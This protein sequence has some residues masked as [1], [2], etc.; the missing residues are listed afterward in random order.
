MK[1]KGL[2]FLV[3]ALLVN[4]CNASWFSSVVHAIT[5]PKSTV[6]TVV[7]DTKGAVDS[8]ADKTDALIKKSDDAIAKGME[9]ADKGIVTAGMKTYGGL[10][11]A[12]K[13]A[14]NGIIHAVDNVSWRQVAGFTLYLIIDYGFTAA[15]TA[16]CGPPCGILGD[17]AGSW[18]SVYTVNKWVGTPNWQK[19]F[20]PYLGNGI[21]LFFDSWSQRGIQIDNLATVKHQSDS[22]A[23]IPTKKM[24]PAQIKSANAW[25]IIARDLAHKIKQHESNQKKTTLP[26]IT[27]TQVEGYHSFMNNPKNPAPGYIWMAITQKYP[28]LYKK[29]YVPNQND[30]MAAS[31]LYYYLIGKT[32][33]MQ[34]IT[35]RASNAPANVLSG[36]IGKDILKPIAQVALIKGGVYKKGG[37]TKGTALEQLVGVQKLD[38]I[39]HATATKFISDEEM[40]FFLQFGAMVKGAVLQALVKEINGG[41]VPANLEISYENGLAQFLKMS[42]QDVALVK[43]RKSKVYTKG[44]NSKQVGWLDGVHANLIRAK[45]SKANLAGANLAGADLGFA[46]LSGANLTGANITGANFYNTNLKGAKGLTAQQIKS[47][48]SFKDATMPDGKKHS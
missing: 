40:K 3:I 25:T 37:T 19:M 9:A 14:K 46:D 35:A 12:Y 15:G 47:A 43:N 33:I 38:D 26:P 5:H 42:K 27:K 10:K 32:P 45:L 44:L 8:L 16:L 1:K 29:G 34:Q 20:G 7:S 23:N 48:E 41:V 28:F 4:N 11:F 24:T 21:A 2:L 30:L 39:V 18:I 17:E 31:Y 13:G 6:E 22:T 36:S